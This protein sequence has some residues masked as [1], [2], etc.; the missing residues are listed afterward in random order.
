[1]KNYK[2]YQKQRYLF[3]WA[4]LFVYFVPYV[5]ATACL[6]PMMQ[7]AQGVKWGIGFAVVALN[8]IPFLQGVFKSFRAHFPFVNLLAWLFVF[9]AWFFT[10]KLFSDYVY[11][12]MTIELTAA[13]GSLV[14]CILW[15]FHRKYKRKARTVSDILKSGLLESDE[16]ESG[17]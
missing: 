17:G 7:A 3:F 1:M 11:T 4:A 15:F 6:L 9:L 5:I 16:D 13:I 14:A 2:T 8:A 12:F 10:M